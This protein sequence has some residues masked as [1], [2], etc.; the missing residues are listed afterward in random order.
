MTDTAN[1]PTDDELHAAWTACIHA[2]G[3]PGAQ[4]EAMQ[5]LRELRDRRTTWYAAENELR[6]ALDNYIGAKS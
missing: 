5:R 6:V 2:E 4:S 1:Q 3:I